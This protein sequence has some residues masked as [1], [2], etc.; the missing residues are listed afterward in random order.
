MEATAEELPVDGVYSGVRYLHLDLPHA[1]GGD[2]NLLQN[3]FGDGISGVA[4]GAVR[5]SP[6]G[7]HHV[8][9]VA[10]VVSAWCVGCGGV[11]TRPS[12]CWLIRKGHSVNNATSNATHEA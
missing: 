7:L 2:W 6:P 10:V 9:C 12:S 8:V 3:Q 4:L 11:V 5:V 1:S